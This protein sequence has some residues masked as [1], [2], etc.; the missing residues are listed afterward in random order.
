MFASVAWMELAGSLV[1]EVMQNGV[2]AATVGWLN[3]FVFILGAGI[4]FLTAVIFTYVSKMR[5]KFQNISILNF[6]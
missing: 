1:G 6:R 4:Y 3:N 2:L 5:Y